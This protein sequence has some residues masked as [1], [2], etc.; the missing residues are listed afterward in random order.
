MV[1]LGLT[2]PPPA[3]LRFKFW[4]HAFFTSVKTAKIITEITILFS[5]LYAI[6]FNYRKLRKHNCFRKT[7]CKHSYVPTKETRC[8]V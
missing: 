7:K 2:L 8:E 3:S 1:E 4:D 5:T 6:F